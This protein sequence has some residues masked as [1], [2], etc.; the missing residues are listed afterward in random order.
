[1]SEVL[2]TAGHR[3]GFYVFQKFRAE[4]LNP[5]NPDPKNS[6]PTGHHCR[7]EDDGTKQQLTKIQAK[8]ANGN[9]SRFLCFL[10]WAFSLKP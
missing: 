8:T 7:A 4:T 2:T 3:K 10:G 6:K 1:V 5:K 9:S